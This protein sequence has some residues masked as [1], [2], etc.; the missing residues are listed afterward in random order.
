MEKTKRMK[1]NDLERARRSA[2]SEYRKTAAE[3]EK[4][5]NYQKTLMIRIKDLDLELEQLNHA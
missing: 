3:I 1:I 2:Y 5:E 4:L